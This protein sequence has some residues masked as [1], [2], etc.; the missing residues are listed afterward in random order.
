M[1]SYSVLCPTFWIGDTGRAIRALGRD[2][3]V[4][5]LYLVSAPTSNMIGLY[6]LPLPTL[7]HEVGIPLEVASEA[8]RRLSE[9]GFAH[10]DPPSEYVFVPAMA[11]YQIGEA[12]KATDN[13]CM[14]IA[15]ELEC[16]RKSRFYADFRRLYAAAFHLPPPSPLQAPPK[17]PRSQDQEQDQEQDQDQDQE[18]VCG[19]PATPTTPPEAPPSPLS[20]DVVEPK[21]ERMAA[22]QLA[23]LR[24]PIFPC[25]GD[26][27][28]WELTLPLVTQWR[29]AYP[30]VDVSAE[31]R[32][33]HAW[34]ISNLN[35][36]KTA[37]GMP[38]FLNAW[39]ARA[40]NAQRRAG[41]APPTAA[42]YT[43]RTAQRK[44][45][46]RNHFAQR[47]GASDEQAGTSGAGGNG[48]GTV[49]NG[50]GGASARAG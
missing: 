33:A 13:R 21:P 44:A 11:R 43:D 47:L 38:R 9:A 8:L 17:P 7:C 16:H 41:P 48:Q 20:S 40:Q 42:S 10:Y 4:V 31:A 18:D 34:V 27:Q 15:K 23:A 25:A 12:L 2:A 5:A 19:G 3:Q 14:A 6:Y 37:K 50:N 30:A 32:A 36:R 29:E 35:D 45:D 22:E 1:R 24:F 26:P 49:P 28:T 39:M 46:V